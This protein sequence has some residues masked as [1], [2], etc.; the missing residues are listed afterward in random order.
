M[1]AVPALTLFAGKG[2]VGK[3][4]LSGAYAVHRALRRKSRVLVLSTDPAHSLADVL[5]V[6]LGERARRVPLAS[7]HAQLYA[8]QIDAPKQFEKFLRSERESILDLAASA[9]IFT[10][11]ELEPLLDTTLPGM[12]EVAAL[13]ALSDLL[14]SG[15]YDEIVVDTA[16]LGHTLR[17]F[18]LP[19]HFARFLTFLE[20]AASRDQ[21]LAAAFARTRLEPSPLIGK[22]AAMVEAVQ[23]ALS[24]KHSRLLLVTTPETFALNETQRARGWLQE[25][26][27]GLQIDG[28]VLNRVIERAG[29]C[30]RCRRRARARAEAEKFLRRHFPGVSLAI[31]PDSGGPVL[32]TKA[33]GAFGEH[34]FGGR[35]LRIAPAAPRAGEAK[36]RPAAWPGLET[37]LSITVG[38]GGVGKTTISAGLAFHQ[39]RRAPKTPVTI[40]STDPAPSLDDV[41]QARVGDQPVTV[42]GDARLQ[43][44]E[45]DSLAEFVE[46]SAA[47]KQRINQALTGGREGGVQV[48]LSFERRLLTALL[49]VVPP[50][51]DDLRDV[52]DDGPARCRVP[53]DECRV[54]NKGKRN[55]DKGR[56]KERGRVARVHTIDHG[57]GADGACAGVAA[58]AGASAALVPPF[59]E[60]AG[61]APYTTA[62]SGS[63]GGSGERGGAGART[64]CPA[65]RRAP[66]GSLAGDAG[67]AAARPGNRASAGGAGRIAGALARAVRQPRADGRGHARMPALPA[68]AAVATGD[69]DIAATALPRPEALLRAGVSARDRR[70]GRARR[71]YPRTMATRLTDEGSALYF[72]GVSR[73]RAPRLP[74]TLRGIDAMAEVE[75]RDCSGLRCWYSRVDRGEYG[76]RLERNM[77]N[78]EWLAN[79]SVHHQRVV[80]SIAEMADILPARFGTVFLGESSL[81]ADVAARKVD[82]VRALKR[83][84][85]ASE[86]GVKVF[87][88]ARP[89][90]VAKPAA[91]GTDYL[92]QK[93]EQLRQRSQPAAPVEL[94]EM[95]AALQKAAVAS[96]VVRG[97]TPQ[98][99]LLWQASFLVKRG[100]EKAFHEV[101]RRYAA[102]LEQVR[103][104]TSGA[105][106][107][108]SFAE[109]PEDTSETRARKQ[110]QAQRKK[111]RASRPRPHR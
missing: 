39:R 3:T 68:R 57:H 8:W 60:N 14:K 101:L 76:E 49:D 29:K 107:P 53:S 87:A 15:E 30:A 1:T 2:G 40:C 83:I 78:L 35:A 99:G 65:A 12:A 102:E 94:P 95:S 27:P 80:G 64:G 16:P 21:A 41:F 48:D 96:V 74:Q 56:S 69:P 54:K 59:I 104:E 19:E 103:I 58:H 77:E 22:W 43:A 42:L 91:S 9:T 110:K 50:G 90:V 72:Y 51:V 88:G 32:G 79:A 55:K 38:K 89:A 28:L 4:T 25:A 66:R 70:R 92:R 108:Y 34:V 100:R 31:A 44:A 52:P 45:I 26:A 105:W 36:L 6:R 11:E 17:L 62:G 84:E 85:G 109:A 73:G 97:K 71:V 93:R 98:P 47:I 106:P 75:S 61:T 18:S 13:L 37:G 81:A 82:L 7:R 23:E 33:L 24:A 111:P 86:W 63:G 67:R 20:T 46:W 5:Q 10:R